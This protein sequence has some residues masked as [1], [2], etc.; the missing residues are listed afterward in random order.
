MVP[1]PNGF[2]ELQDGHQ[3]CPGALAEY[4]GDARMFM[5][6]LRIWEMACRPS[7]ASGLSPPD[8]RER[9]RF[10]EVRV[11]R[12]S[13][14][15]SCK[16]FVELTLDLERSRAY[17]DEAWGLGGEAPGGR[18]RRTP[19]E[20]RKDTGS[21][22]GGG[23]AGWR[24]AAGEAAVT[25]VGGRSGDSGPGGLLAKMD[26]SLMRLLPPAG[27][28]QRE[29]V[30]RNVLLGGGALH[31]VAGR[32]SGQ[33]RMRFLRTKVSSLVARAPPG[34]SCDMH[35][36]ACALSKS[37]SVVSQPESSSCRQFSST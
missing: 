13:E 6:E 24:R 2:R 27:G 9:M 26:C 3:G 36:G 37:V 12:A 30:W 23:W 34:C 14:D 31:R 25:G 16:G 11:A 10:E 29:A 28:V 20:N 1:D 33:V 8:P 4:V 19:G 35:R 21:A 32:T 18:W 15:S 5:A 17:L 22:L 7:K